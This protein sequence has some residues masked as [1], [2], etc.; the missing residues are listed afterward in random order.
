MRHRVTNNAELLLVASI[1]LCSA[2]SSWANHIHES[3][4]EKTVKVTIEENGKSI[5]LRQ[6]DVLE[7]M[8]PSTFGTGFSWRVRS[9]ASSVLLS[10]GKPE[11]RHG[12]GDHGK[13]GV[14]EYQVFRFTAKSPGVD[15]LE[16]EYVRPWES[17]V[18]PARE[19]SLKIR[20]K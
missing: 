7:L 12:Q 9:G 18:S 16:L 14:T 4:N 20:V 10:H 13:A 5:E 19:Y 2:C 11:V 8:L 3:G 1:L 6:R 15:K 17:D